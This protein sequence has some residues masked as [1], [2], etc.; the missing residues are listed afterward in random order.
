MKLGLTVDDAYYRDKLLMNNITAIDI[1]SIADE[2][3]VFQQDSAPAN[4]AHQTV[5][6]LRR[7]TLEFIAADTWPPNSP[8]VKPVV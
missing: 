8:Y 5:E 1:R 6:L 4:R 3:Y 7:E 2:I